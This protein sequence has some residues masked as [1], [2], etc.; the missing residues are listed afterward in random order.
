MTAHFTTEQKALIFRLRGQGKS[1]R[2]IAKQLGSSH[3]GIDVILK[4]QQRVP[5]P[6]T[7]TPR[8]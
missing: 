2:E 8:Q 6:V 5:R 7:W 4:G 1:L 3:S